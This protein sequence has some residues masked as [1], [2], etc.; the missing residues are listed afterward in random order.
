VESGPLQATLYAVAA[1]LLIGAA[2]LLRPASLALASRALFPAGAL[3]GLA[4]AAFALQGVFAAPRSLVLPLGLPDLPFHVRLDALSAFFVMLLV[5][6]WH[7][8]PKGS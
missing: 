8:G 2:G 5:L 7:P 4:L 3:V 1:W 6:G